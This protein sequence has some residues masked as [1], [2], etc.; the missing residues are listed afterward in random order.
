MA[1]SE[2]KPFDQKWKKNGNGE[3][4]GK[5]QT[6]GKD[7]IPDDLPPHMESMRL[8]AFEMSQWAEQVTRDWD[9]VSQLSGRMNHMAEQLRQMDELLRK[10][11]ND[12]DG[13]MTPAPTRPA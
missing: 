4:E 11:R 9:E 12:V 7:N 6:T 13:I 2:K 3:W 8:W 10:L 5:W 1:H